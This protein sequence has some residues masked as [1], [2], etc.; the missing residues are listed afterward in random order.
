MGIVTCGGCGIKFDRSGD[1]SEFIK[2]K[3]YHKGCAAVK[4]EKMNLDAYVC[5][6]FRLKTPGPMNNTLFKKYKEKHGYTYEGMEQALKYFYEI[7]RNSP[8]KSEERVGI[9]PYVYQDAQNYFQFLEDRTD[10]IERRGL[11]EEIEKIEIN[12]KATPSKPNKSKQDISDLNSLFDG[13]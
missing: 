7:K 4:H 10:R 1:G 13:E 3:W 8:D 11:D 9:I 5:K 6:L 2:S 12:I